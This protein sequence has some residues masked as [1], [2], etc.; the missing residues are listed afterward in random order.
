MAA[1][2][3]FMRHFAVPWLSSLGLDLKNSNPEGRTLKNHKESDYTLNKYS[4]GIV[5][6]FEDGIVEVTLGP[7]KL[8]RQF[9]AENGGYFD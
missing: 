8:N 2:S 1:F 5:Y 4:Q 6:K 3:Y 7:K 9:F